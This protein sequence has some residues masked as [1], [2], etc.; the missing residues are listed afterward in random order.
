MFMYQVN[1]VISYRSSWYKNAKIM[2]FIYI[3]M[4]GS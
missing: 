2:E 3:T 1:K 4:R